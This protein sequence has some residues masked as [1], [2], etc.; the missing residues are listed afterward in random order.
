MNVSTLQ[1]SSIDEVYA[2]NQY[3][4]RRIRK[5]EITNQI[6]ED[7]YMEVKNMLLVEQHS[8]AEQ[9][10]ALQSAF[11]RDLEEL[12]EYYKQQAGKGQG[13]SRRLSI[14]GS[15]NDFSDYD[16][17]VAGGYNLKF[18][19]SVKSADGYRDAASVSSYSRRSASSNSSPV[20]RNAETGPSSPPVSVRRCASDSA[21]LPS[22]SNI[23]LPG[24]LG[25]EFLMGSHEDDDDDEEESETETESESDSDA[26]VDVQFGHTEKDSIAAGNSDA[27]SDEG[28]ETEEEEEEDSEFFLADG[29]EFVATFP[30]DPLPANSSDEDADADT[31]D[32]GDEES[33]DDGY[34]DDTDH[35]LEITIEQLH[36]P[37]THS[38]ADSYPEEEDG[39]GGAEGDV[40]V[41]FAH[42]SDYSSLEESDWAE[43]HASESDT[44]DIPTFASTKGPGPL[45]VRAIRAPLAP[46]AGSPVVE[47]PG[48]DVDPVKAVIERYYSHP[49]TPDIAADIDDIEV[50]GDD[51]DD[52]AH[53]AGVPLHSSF[54]DSQAAADDDD[55]ARRHAQRARE[56]H[57]DAEP[58]IEA[59]PRA[60][61]G[62]SSSSIDEEATAREI[63]RIATL[64]VDQRIAKFI[65][66]A[67]SHLLQCARGGLSL[68][69][70]LLNLESLSAKFEASHESVLCAFVESLYQVAET[71]DDNGELLPLPRTKSSYS[72]G[73]SSQFLPSALSRKAREET[74]S[75]IQTAMRIVQLL[76]TLIAVPKDQDVVLHQLEQLCMANESVRAAKHGMILRI[77]YESEVIDKGPIVQ[78]YS[79][80]EHGDAS[81]GRLLRENASSL[82]EQLTSS[83]SSSCSLD[84]HH[85]RPA[86]GIA[87]TC[88]AGVQ[89]K[90]SAT[91]LSPIANLAALVGRNA[92]TDSLLPPSDENT[93]LHSQSSDSE[94][95]GKN[96]DS[97]LNARRPHISKHSAPAPAAAA[98]ATTTTAAGLRPAKRVS[99]VIG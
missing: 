84:E 76:H 9:K 41:K 62:G 57:R 86:A 19:I 65:F 74:A 10:M 67:S 92:S 96:G 3:L 12:A 48:I 52:N 70:M 5:L 83:S 87:S 14:S 47:S 11:N 38:D 2:T 45:S 68:G 23:V 98:A 36:H 15:D 90:A 35:E 27:K 17:S 32:T 99:F 89:A 18:D 77:L 64:P 54:E 56:T 53:S 26:S 37:T 94:C 21:F 69:F 72:S 82:I 39:D 30:R 85:G 28:W 80:P 1:P 20:M 22:T 49:G 40:S 7:A 93:T 6:I 4:L 78:W 13:G 75:P 29:V 44:D 81:C 60:N 71:I 73:S 91:A 95:S 66:R 59:G 97:I 25:I 61:A 50:C 24:D 43:Q 79:L 51:D 88:S 31:E 16:D 63:E 33:D 58:R 55:F 34:Y 46:G 42:C 8:K